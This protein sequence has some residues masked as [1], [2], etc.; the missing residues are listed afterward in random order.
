MRELLVKTLL[1][2]LCL[3]FA[4]T[5]SPASGPVPS[6]PASDGMAT[7]AGML[8][9]VCATA[10]AAWLRSLR[11]IG[12]ASSSMGTGDAGWMPPLAYAALALLEPRWCVFLPLAAYDLACA[13]PPVSGSASARPA[14]Y[15]TGRTTV[16]LAVDIVVRF[17]WAL[18]LLRPV[19]AYLHDGP[20]AAVV[21]PSTLLTA[22]LCTALGFALGRSE[23]DVAG[24]RRAL[25]SERD[26]ARQEARDA[27][28]RIAD[29][30]EERARA[31]RVA[32]LGERTRIAREIHDNV[33][34]LLTRAIMQAK[35]GG[36]VADATDDRTASAGFAALGAT[37]DDAMTMVRRSVHDLEDDGTDFAA[38]ID[39][40]AHAFDGAS[41]GF[42]V[43]MTCDVA[44]AP[45]PVARCLATVIRESLSNTARHSAAR[46]ATVTLR[47]FPALWQLV[48]LDPGP[49][50]DEGAEPARVA[51]EAPRGM[52]LADIA[53][54]V[55]AVGGTSA[56]GP[57]GDGWRV[58]A[59]IPK[60]P[61]A[62]HDDDDTNGGA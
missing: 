7:T 11:P 48:V 26:T 14:V 10:L 13:G 31:V 45:A 33:G 16:R 12:P 34:H 22:A 6:W 4:V 19:A 52:G 57:Y 40:A 8:L 41:P 43:A 27:R 44:S 62:V 2:G 59:A 36:A 5:A 15:G 37:L 1:F 29:L 23:R 58:F 47:D 9:A 25:R 54:R 55:R 20:S 28:T 39:A 30:D 50:L 17:A 61:W 49:R 18:P 24:S 32:A 42:R 56:C 53:E 3:T 46:T 60:G 35:A 21:R 38:Q 51:G